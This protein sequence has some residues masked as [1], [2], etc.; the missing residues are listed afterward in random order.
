MKVHVT[1]V[2]KISKKS[3]KVMK[4]KLE[5]LVV[6][7]VITRTKFIKKI[8]HL[9]KKIIIST[10]VYKAKKKELKVELNEG[11]ITTTKY[12]EKSFELKQRKATIIKIG[13]KTFAKKIKVLKKKVEKKKITVERYREIVYNYRSHM[14]ITLTSYQTRITWIEE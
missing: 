6:N 4:S 9:K 2:T 7:Q 14:T 8:T 13:R 12:Q 3:F 1:P 11:L 5:K 10:K